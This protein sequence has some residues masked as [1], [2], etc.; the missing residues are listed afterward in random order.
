MTYA[1]HFCSQQYLE[2]MKTGQICIKFSVTKDILLFTKINW[3][4][5]F[6]DATFSPVKT[7]FGT[8][9]GSVTHDVISLAPPSTL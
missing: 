3:S 1:L 9:L 8:L 6:L 5:A 7:I 4:P 2:S